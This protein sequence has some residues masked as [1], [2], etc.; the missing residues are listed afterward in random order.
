[1]GI[2]NPIQPGYRPHFC[3]KVVVVFEPDEVEQHAHENR[4]AKRVV[5]LRLDFGGMF[6]EYSVEILG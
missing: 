4:D 1:M 6:T 3:L 5:H 2:Y